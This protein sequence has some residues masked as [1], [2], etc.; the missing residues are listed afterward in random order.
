MAETEIDAIRDLLAASPRSSNL[1]E[2]RERLDGFGAHYPVPPDVTVV[3]VDAGGVS[4][5][6]TGS[7]GADPTRVVLFLHGGGY[8][9]GSLNSHRHMMAETGRAAGSRTL[10]L[11][12]RLAPEHPFPAAL[13][14]ALAG[15]RF[16]LES[17]VSPR[18]IVLSGESAGGGL[19]V[20]TALSL[21]D[22][23][24]PLPRCLWLT[25]P[26][27]DL[28]MTGA[29][30]D[31]KA[32]VDPLIQREYLMELVEAYCAGKDAATPLISPLHA[33]LGGLPP[34]LIQVGSAETLLDDSLRLAGVAASADVAVTLQ[35][36]PHMIHAWHMFYPQLA[37][38]RRSLASAGA[39]IRTHLGD[40]TA[41]QHPTIGV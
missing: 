38:G 6:W 3:P 39:F 35:V 27:V 4:A 24:L 15:Y 25:S 12:Y 18:N 36:W 14:D 34:M 19:A 30:M 41:V 17:G 9:S 20:A 29:S 11:D 26:W 28:E 8:V 1:A 32:A 7:P 23:G 10:A 16:L 40:G 5:E 31:T 13:D 21:R 22:A 33:D 37:E 2:R